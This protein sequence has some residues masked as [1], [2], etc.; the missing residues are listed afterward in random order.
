MVSIELDK[1]SFCYSNGEAE[2]VFSDFN[3]HIAPGDWLVLVGPSGAGKTTLIK[4]AKGLLQPQGGEIRING[5]A[6]PAGKLN[7]L[8]ACVF[9]NPENQIVSPVV[10][11]DVAFGLELCGLRP[12]R[13][14]MRVEEALRWVDLWERAGDFSHFLSGGEQQRLILAGALALRKQCLLLDDPLCM[15][16]GRTRARV[17]EVLKSVHREE[18]CTMVQTT[19]LLEEAVFARRLVAIESGRLLFDGPPVEFFQEKRLIER[20]ALEVP[21]IARLGEMLAEGG[22]AKAAGVC[23]VEQVLALLRDSQNV[24]CRQ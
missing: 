13:I 17:L 23:T 12:E 7:H 24:S 9:A 22:L 20:L 2:P 1:I 18:S 14:A 15:V 4:L 3:L 5:A 19:N 6:L 10:A 8:A 16:D 21:A 11:E